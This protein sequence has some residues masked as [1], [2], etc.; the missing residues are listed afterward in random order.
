VETLPG[1]F[2]IR[3]VVLGPSVGDQIVI[4]SGVRHGERVATRGNFLIDSQMQL[5]GNPSL[6]DP[7]KLQPTIDGAKSVEMIAALSNLS[8]DDRV[9]VE[10]Q[11]IC[12]VAE[13]Q[14]GLMG[15]PR[16]IDVNGTSVFI[17][18]DGCREKLLSE[19]AKY[20]AKLAAMPHEEPP[21]HQAP[22]THL[23]MDLPPIGIPQIIQPEAADPATIERVNEETID[24]ESMAERL[25]TPRE[26]TIR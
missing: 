10:K 22:A 9:L 13:Y 8:P 21:Y 24:A 19:P 4:R 5:A 2:E 3:R 12:P 25:S 16:K 17:C 14:L 15:T 18:C 26:E 20:L 6:I 1:R 11:K 7:S 23:Q